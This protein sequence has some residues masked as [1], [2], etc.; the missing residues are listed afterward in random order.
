MHIVSRHETYAIIR[1]HANFT[2]LNCA[3]TALTLGVTLFGNEVFLMRSLDCF[4]RG[5][6]MLEPGL[7]CDIVVNFVSI[8]IYSPLI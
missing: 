4:F 5:G 7:E 1:L 8:T 3:N 6:V 2:T